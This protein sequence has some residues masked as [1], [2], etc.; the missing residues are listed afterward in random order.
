SNAFILQ[1]LS[2]IKYYGAKGTT[3]RRLILPDLMSGGKVNLVAT[4]S[5][6]SRRWNAKGE[7]NWFEKFKI[8]V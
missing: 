8:G 6:V 4:E 7:K 3:L 2:G 1:A 5:N